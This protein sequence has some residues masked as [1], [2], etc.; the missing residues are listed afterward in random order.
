M[1]K[2][3]ILVLLCACIAC[4]GPTEDPQISVDEARQL[5]R[6][7]PLTE[8]IQEERTAIKSSMKQ[9]F[10]SLSASSREELL[11]LLSDYRIAEG[12]EKDAAAEAVWKFVFTT[13]STLRVAVTLTPEQLASLQK[14]TLTRNADL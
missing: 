14:A 12:S 7:H 5:I 6:N 10:S 4:E 1:K 9:Y 2:L 3:T 8:V 13:Q 11:S